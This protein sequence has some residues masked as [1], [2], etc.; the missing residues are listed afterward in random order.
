MFKPLLSLFAVLIFFLLCPNEQL[1]AQES[2]PLLEFR[3]TDDTDAS[4]WQKMEVSRS[5]ESIFVSSEVSL[6]G[7]HIEKVSFCKDPNGNPSVGPT[8]T[9]D[10]ANAIER[11]TSKNLNKKLAI[12]LDGKV[13]SAPKN[14]STIAMEVQVSGSFDKR[15][16]LTF[17]NA[18]VL[19]ELPSSGK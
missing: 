10:G 19:R 11:T 7:G 18:I 15:D 6:H 2:T 16:L 12:L 17:F 3:L 5:G 9:E 14:Q 8:L 1:S 4:G 13:V